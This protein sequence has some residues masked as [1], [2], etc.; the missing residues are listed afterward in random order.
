MKIFCMII[1]LL[2]LGSVTVKGKQDIKN[3]IIIIIWI[4]AGAFLV[5][6]PLYLEFVK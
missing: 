6:F 2:M 1:G 3:T 4:L 5:G